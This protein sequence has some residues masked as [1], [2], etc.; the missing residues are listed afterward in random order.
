MLK[1]CLCPGGSGMA[2]RFEGEN[3]RDTLKVAQRIS[4]AFAFLALVWVCLERGN[5]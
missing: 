5:V 2:G 1:V 3:Y 4:L